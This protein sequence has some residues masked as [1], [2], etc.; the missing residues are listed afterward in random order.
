MD[1]KKDKDSK[2]VSRGFREFMKVL[3]CESPD[4]QDRDKG[5]EGL[6]LQGCVRNNTS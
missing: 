1:M 3:F 6:F 5:R 2:D 4:Q